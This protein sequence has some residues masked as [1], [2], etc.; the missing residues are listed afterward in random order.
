MCVPI[1]NCDGVTCENGGTCGEVVRFSLIIISLKAHDFDVQNG[2]RS[3]V[4]PMAP[5]LF[6]TGHFHVMCTHSF[7]EK[8]RPVYTMAFFTKSEVPMLRGSK[9]I[10]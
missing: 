6:L 4:P 10:V 9:V 1:D 7:T 2:S 3:L 8:L 5:E